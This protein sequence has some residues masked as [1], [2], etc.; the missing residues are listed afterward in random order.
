MLD[1]IGAHLYDLPDADIGLPQIAQWIEERIKTDY[2]III[3]DPITAA[4]QTRDPWI[5]DAKFINGVKRLA[6]KSGARIVLT[7][8][9]KK[10]S[11]SLV[12]MDSQAGSA[13]YTRFTQTI[14]WLEA[15]NDDKTV[16]VHT[17]VGRGPA[18]VNRAVH[19]LAARN[20]M[21]RGKKIGY[22]FS[23]ET[24]TF[25]EVGVIAKEQK[26]E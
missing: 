18:T 6:R 16:T 4:V 21:G 19:I 25:T 12:D 15:Y 20:S 1:R 8:H 23:S 13:A 22:V 26:H 17:C 7:T 14:L 3:V 10:G 24:L 9:P 11:S 2:R 5:Q